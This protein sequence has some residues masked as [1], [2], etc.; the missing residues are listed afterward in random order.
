MIGG[1]VHGAGGIALERHNAAPQE[2]DD[3][4]PG[5]SRGLMS[6]GIAGQTAELTEMA[7][8]SGQKGAIRHAYAS[9]PPGA[10][11]GEEEWEEYWSLYE[12]AMG[13]KTCPFSEAI[14]DKPGPDG[15]P[16]HRHR[17]YLALTERGTLV[18]LGH[19]YARQEA[20]SRIMEVRTGQSLTK[21]AHNIRA[22]R[23]IERLGFPEVVAAMRDA[24][25]MDGQDRKS[26][27]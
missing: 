24:G 19:D 2:A 20:V 26:V 11:W 6:E 17:V 12:K 25:L 27:V 15:R 9:P 1:A 3:A 14:H 8:A 16:P 5:T 10:D 21:G 13:L 7:R 18:R 4:R 23:T 22:I